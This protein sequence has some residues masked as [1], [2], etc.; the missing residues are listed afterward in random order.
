MLCVTKITL[1]CLLSCYINPF[2]LASNKILSRITKEHEIA[3]PKFLTFDERWIMNGGTST[4]VDEYYDYKKREEKL[5][6]MKLSPK[7]DWSNIVIMITIYQSNETD[8]LI[9]A[10]FGTWMKQADEGLDV[11][12]V[13]DESDERSIDEILPD[14]NNV[15]PKSHL[16]KSVAPD[17]GKHLR[18]KMIDS[19]KEM[20][21]LFG[22]DSK[23][24]YFIKMDTDTFLLPENLLSYVQKIESSTNGQPVLFGNCVGRFYKWC[25]APGGIYGMNRMT[26]QEINN[27]FVSHPD[28]TKEYIFFD[29]GK[30]S[31]ADRSYNNLLEHEDCMVSY[32]YRKATGYPNVMNFR[33]FTSSI[34]HAHSIV[35][36]ECP[37]ISYHTI[38]DPKVYYEYYEMF[39]HE[40]KLKPIEE[41]TSDKRNC[42]DVFTSYF[43]QWIPKYYY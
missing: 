21:N 32:A 17:E 3:L 42:E 19:L 30:K 39:Y 13:T 11:V 25:Y 4:Y 15:S 1:I 5:P 14:L 6:I 31:P 7:I 2:A 10:H 23:K 33:F 27:Y 12:F 43:N 24:K 29:Y 37:P 41:T 26:L 35:D 8:Q 36:K 40:G 16:F 20:E 38:K 18:F 22:N 28:I 9:K 34:N